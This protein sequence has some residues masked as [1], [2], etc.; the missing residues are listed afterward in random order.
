MVAHA[1][2]SRT[3]G[4]KAESQILYQSGLHS[5]ILP[6]NKT[7][8]NMSSRYTYIINIENLTLSVNINLNLSTV[9]KN[10]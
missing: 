6:Q 7:K 5:E 1:C 3:Q 4:A 8:T 10:P 2:N 9:K